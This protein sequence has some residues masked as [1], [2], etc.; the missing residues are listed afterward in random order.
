MLRQSIGQRI[1]GITDGDAAVQSHPNLAGG[2]VVRM[3]PVGAR[4]SFMNSEGIVEGFTRFNG[5]KRAAVHHKRQ[6]QSM[7][8][9]CGFF[10]QIVLEMNDHTVTF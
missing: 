8:V 1:I 3:V 10:G 7:P 6:V 2:A 9:Y 4:R 5:M